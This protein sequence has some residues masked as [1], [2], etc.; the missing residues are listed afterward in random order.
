MRWIALPLVAAAV[1]GAA[2][3]L[4]EAR[5]VADTAAPLIAAAAAVTPVAAA[6]ASVDTALEVPAVEAPAAEAPPAEEPDARGS[7]RGRRLRPPET[8]PPGRDPAAGRDAAAG[9]DRR[10]RPTR[11]RR[12]R[13]RRRLERRRLSQPPRTPR[14]RR[15]PVDAPAIP[16]PAPGGSP[17]TEAAGNTP[18]PISP[19]APLIT[20]DVGPAARA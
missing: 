15:P 8:P 14:L 2:I 11:R 17:A 7:A 19:P 9:R 18:R 6:A 4:P 3:A 20:A 5:S 1:G 16:P 12:P 10:P 13:R